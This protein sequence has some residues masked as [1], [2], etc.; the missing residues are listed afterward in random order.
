[1]NLDFRESQELER[2]ASLE[3]RGLEGNLEKMV[4]RERGAVRAFL[5]TLATRGSQAGRAPR[6]TKAKRALLAPQELLLAPDLW[7]KKGN[8]VTQAPPG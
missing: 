4:K 2:K 1:M 5:A 8:E 6:G 7:E 3:S